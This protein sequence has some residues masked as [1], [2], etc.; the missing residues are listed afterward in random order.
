M[1]EIVSQGFNNALSKITGQA[2]ITEQNIE[3]AVRDVRISLLEADVELNVVKSFI[4]RVKEKALGRLVKTRVAQGQKKLSATPAEHFIAIC[5]EEL[6]YLLCG[7]QPFENSAP[8]IYKKPL[9][10]IMLVGL[11]GTGKTTTASKLAHY[12]IKEKKKPML[13]A[14]DIYRPAAVEQLKVLGAQLDVPV[15]HLEG[16]APPQ[17]CQQALQKAREIH[18]DT[19]IF[20]TAGRLSID[21]Q[22]MQELEAI[23][24]LTQPENTLLVIDA[25]SGQD[26]V[27]TG[28][29]F[30]KRLMLSGFILTKMDGDARGGA[31]LS[32]RAITGKPIRFIGMGETAEKLEVFRAQGLASRILGM[33]DVVGLIQDFEQVVDE[34][35]A[36]KEAEKLMSGRFNFNDF[37][38][39][40]RMIQKLGSLKDIFE[41]MPFFGPGGLPKEGINLDDSQLT[42]IEAMIQSMTQKERILT[43]NIT[44]SRM[45]RIAKGSGRPITEVK[46]LVERFKTMQE[47]MQGFGSLA[48][49][50]GGGFLDKIPGFKQLSQLKN[51]KNMDL[52]KLM[53]GM[54][55]GGLP[56]LPPGFNIPKN[57]LPPGMN[58]PFA[59]P[60]K[61]SVGVINKEDKKGKKDKRKAQK[62]AR[63]KA[64]K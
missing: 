40:L 15:F 58:N 61:T 28:A 43:E 20:D 54:Q 44:E 47:M 5:Q 41:K 8:I 39:Q 26:A 30:N 64:R 57:M 31:A 19:V 37:L 2:T 24:S 11:Q 14:A 23:Q 1:L 46:D 22:L 34:K 63:K 45:R 62:E 38:S 35:E 4:E 48:A 3:E 56:N 10:T 36:Q 18:C 49:S 16:V 55:Q 32:I 51:L 7:Q 50:S 13:V 21:E 33:G 29:E 53:G 52:N 25:M 17:M 27:R 9:T 59:T 60:S 42:R 12:L 6:E